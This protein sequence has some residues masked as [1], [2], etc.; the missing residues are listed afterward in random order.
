MN[1]KMKKMFCILVGIV[2]VFCMTT[3]V[4]AADDGYT[5]TIRVFAGNM[6]KINGEE[7]LVFP[8][9]TYGEEWSFD[10]NQVQPSNGKYYVKGIRESGLDND[11]VSPAAFQVHGDMDFVVAYGIKGN[12]VAYTVHF[13]RSSDGSVLADPVTYY[14]NVGDK[15]VVA[16]KFIEGY[17]PKYYNITGTLSENA[18]ENDFVFQY[19]LSPTTTAQSAPSGV[20]PASPSTAQGGTKD[21][22]GS[23]DQSE[24]GKEQ[25][26]D[27]S[28][29]G[30]GE[31]LDLDP[32]MAGP[33]DPV[34][35]EQSKSGGLSTQWLVGGIGAVA[36]AL[37]V[38]FVVTSSRRKKDE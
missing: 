4:M 6:G 26:S 11:A 2:L 10:I 5:Y 1:I 23:E 30:P 38:L 28:Q 24:N 36:A 34:V 25:Q 9:M 35:E 17:Y 21:P 12:E 13:V 31:I 16:C 14:G 33:G 19:D 7:V 29:S 37:L 32:P 8:G 15:P 3:H 27:Q 22:N 20:L 18:S